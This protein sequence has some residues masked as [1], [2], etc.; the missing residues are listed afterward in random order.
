M[1][2]SEQ[3]LYREL[4]D[5]VRH[6]WE[7]NGYEDGIED[8]FR[9][10]KGPAHDS[11]MLGWYDGQQVRAIREANYDGRVGLQHI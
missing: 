1:T 2:P 3:K 11:Y 4:T 10:P 5:C 7:R 8:N 9:A 6:S